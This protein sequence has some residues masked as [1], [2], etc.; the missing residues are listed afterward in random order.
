MKKISMFVCSLLFVCS[1]TTAPANA[2]LISV[3]ADFPAP[4][5]IL[6]FAAEYN[7]DTWL[8]TAGPVQVGNPVGRDI[9]WSSTTSNSVIGDSGYG[10]VDNG[11][12]DT[13]RDGYVG[14]NTSDGTMRFDFNDGLL[15][16]VGG[17]INYAPFYYGSPVISALGDGDVLLESWTLPDIAISTT[18]SNQGAFFGITRTT[19]E[20]RA[21]A[22]SNA[23]IVL[24]DLTFSDSTVN[25][26][27][28]DNNV[29]PEPATMALLG[30]GLFG[31]A[32]LRKKKVSI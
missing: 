10:L 22:L 19:A 31:F 2:S 3:L 32:G 17:F 23:Y 11:Y 16:A 30:S 21:F 5:T 9:T 25:P 7:T 28:T 20:I 6:D 8:F 29:V 27:A 18:E 1:L 4:Y 14:L 12:W 24:D 15:S 13:A 26:P